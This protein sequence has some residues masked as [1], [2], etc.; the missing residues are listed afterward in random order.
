MGHSKPLVLLA[1]TV[2][3]GLVAVVLSGELLNRGVNLPSAGLEFGLGAVVVSALVAWLGWHVY[4]LR[5]HKPTW[6]SAVGAPR[7]A[8]LSL[9]L[10][11]VG[12]VFLGFFGGQALFLALNLNNESLVELLPGKLVAS[13]GALVMVGVGLGV[14]KIC[15]INPEDP[16]S[17]PPGTAPAPA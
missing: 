10:S 14:E 15:T 17:K 16:D 9:A 8:A 4:R 2:V 12:A 13:A 5:Q 11:H 1:I 6:L 7:V 3:A